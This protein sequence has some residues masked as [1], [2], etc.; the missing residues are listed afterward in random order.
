MTLL[1]LRLLLLAAG[2]FEPW[3]HA[4]ALRENLTVASTGAVAGV[5][6]T[7]LPVARL[8]TPKGSMLIVEAAGARW[9]LGPF[10]DGTELLRDQLGVR[11]P[12]K[13]ARTHELFFDF[14]SAPTTFQRTS[15]SFVLVRFAPPRRWRS[16]SPWL[17]PIEGDQLRS[18][19]P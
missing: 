6:G 16:A 5:D 2:D 7:P 18:P 10:A 3:I 15:K 4:E 1:A 12:S 17:R 9:A 8:E 14:R 11:V 13:V 19:Q